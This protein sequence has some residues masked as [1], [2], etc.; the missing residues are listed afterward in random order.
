[1]VQQ[2]PREIQEEIERQKKEFAAQSKEKVVEGREEENPNKVKL[3][4]EGGDAAQL[5]LGSL[6]DVNKTLVV[7]NEKTLSPHALRQ[8]IR[9]VIQTFVENFAYM[10]LCREKNDYTVF[11]FTGDRTEA[12]SM[13]WECIVNRGECRGI[14]KTADGAYE[15]WI[16]NADENDANV[17][18][19]FPCNNCIIKC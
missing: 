2:L 13:L 17:Y 14:E 10:L 11:L 19:L 9:E 1:M 15:I 3:V 7:E 6:Y 18:Y 5:P 12:R 16:Y 8:K 4:D